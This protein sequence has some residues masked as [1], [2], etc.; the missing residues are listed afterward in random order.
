MADWDARFKDLKGVS[1]YLA[2]PTHRDLHPLVVD[3][4]ARTIQECSRVGIDLKVDV[5]S[6]LGS[7]AIHIARSQMVDEFSKS[8]GELLFFLDSDITFEPEAFLQV[9]WLT[10]QYGVIACLYGGRVDGRSDIVAPMEIKPDGTL[11]YVTKMVKTP[12]GVL[13][14]PTA[15]GGMGFC[16]FHRD[17]IRKMLESTDQTH[18]IFEKAGKPVEKYP[19]KLVS[20]FDYVEG[21]GSRGEDHCFFLDLE[22]LGFPCG[23]WPYPRLGHV[24]SKSW[25]SCFSDYLGD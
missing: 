12:E 14:W 15:R 11:E 25:Y 22:R 21:L 3:S 24:G 5:L 6:T 4:L 1:V 10:K 13:F 20:A 2:I 23:I 17:V 18:W 9:V 7:S 8:G 16:C 19:I